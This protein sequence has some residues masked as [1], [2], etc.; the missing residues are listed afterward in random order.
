MEDAGEEPAYASR[1]HEA[2]FH[3]LLSEGL[4]V[5]H[6]LEPGLTG[7]WLRGEPARVEHGSTSLVPVTHAVE[8]YVADRARAYSRAAAEMRNMRASLDRIVEALEEEM[9]R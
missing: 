5:A 8:N 4:A 1:L 9:M 3:G 7:A 2:N 6:L